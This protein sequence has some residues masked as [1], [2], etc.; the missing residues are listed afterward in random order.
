MDPA[1]PDPTASDPPD[2][3]EID[4]G[5]AQDLIDRS[6]DVDPPAGVDKVVEAHPGS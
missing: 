6:V 2:L 1:L 5:D 4:V 3:P